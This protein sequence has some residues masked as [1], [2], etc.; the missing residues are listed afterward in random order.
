MIFVCL[1][2]SYRK[3]LDAHQTE[4]WLGLL[5]E[6]YSPKYYW[7]EAVWIAR[8]LVLA[9]AQ[10]FLRDSGWCDIITS[11]TLVGS[12]CIMLL[13][14]PLRFK[15]ENVLEVMVTALLLTTWTSSKTQEESIRWTMLVLNF[16]LV[17]LF[18]LLL[19]YN[20]LK[21]LKK[22]CFGK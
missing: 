8:R 19:G 21:N 6:N 11:S 20:P 13:L 4:Y 10:S 17:L 3:V 9:L 1:L 16:L 7:W 2:F 12:L 18:L 15:L 22:R 14:E 5:Y